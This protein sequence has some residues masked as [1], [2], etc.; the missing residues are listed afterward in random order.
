MIQFFS[1]G[2]QFGERDNF[3]LIE[4]NVGKEE[5]ASNQAKMLVTSTF[6]LSYS[7]VRRLLSE[8]RQKLGFCC[9]DLRY[10]KHRLRYRKYLGCSMYVF[11]FVAL[12]TT[13]R[14]FAKGMLKEANMEK[15][16]SF[17]NPPE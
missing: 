16:S 10:I 12:Y 11:K 15:E 3:S 13:Y 8:G 17:S 14:F 4:N 1:D 5:N 7:H 9:K 2:K 6:S